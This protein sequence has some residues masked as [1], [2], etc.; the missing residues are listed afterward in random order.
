MKT[1]IKYLS[2][3]PLKDDLLKELEKRNTCQVYHKYST[4][5]DETFRRVSDWC[6]GCILKAV[7]DEMK[8][9]EE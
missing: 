6:D 1:N 3:P 4:V 5:C 2:N 8:W 9:K 7:L